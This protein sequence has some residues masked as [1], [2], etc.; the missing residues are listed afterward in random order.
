MESKLYTRRGVAHGNIQ[1]IDILVSTKDED[2][3]A[4]VTGYGVMGLPPRSP[5]RLAPEVLQGQ[6]AGYEKQNDIWG[7]GC[8]AY[9]MLVGYPPF[10]LS[11]PEEIAAAEALEGEEERAA[12]LGKIKERDE[13]TRAKVIAGE[14][15]FADLYWR[16]I[17]PD[18]KD[19]VQMM[20][21]SEP[22]VRPSLEQIANHM[23]LESPQGPRGEDLP[24]ARR[25]LA[26]LFA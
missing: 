9:M 2:L 8:L 23:F 12:A 15:P 21:T 6:E 5:Q 26:E 14:V 10:A 20:M 11:T 13:M 22:E 4:M 1:L 3:D 19:L 17:G 7:L 16:D 24:E 25:K 18:A